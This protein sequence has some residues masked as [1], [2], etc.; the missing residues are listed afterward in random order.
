MARVDEARSLL[1]LAFEDAAAFR[2]L[3]SSGSVRPA[4]ALF[5][6]QQAV[7]K[8]IKAVLVLNGVPFGR[9][10]D[11]VELGYRAEEAVPDS[12]FAVDQL[13]RLNP[14]AVAFRYAELTVDLIETEE[15]DELVTSVT[16]WADSRIRMA[17]ERADGSR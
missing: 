14:Y 4:T 2:V 12:P 1:A 3:I 6:A 15:A 5:H 11:L 9:T 13:I 16:A 8:A 17:A 7:E 10:H